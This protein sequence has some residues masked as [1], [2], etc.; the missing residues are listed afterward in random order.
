[1]TVVG[2]SEGQEGW[3]TS[4]EPHMSGPRAHDRDPVL[5]RVLRG[6]WKGRGQCLI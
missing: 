2:E 6:P 1:M 5:F 4:R 3:R